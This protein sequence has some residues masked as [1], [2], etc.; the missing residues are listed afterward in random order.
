MALGKAGWKN[1]FR[2]VDLELSKLSKIFWTMTRGKEHQV[3]WVCHNGRWGLTDL[4]PPAGSQRVSYLSCIHRIPDRSR[5]WKN[6]HSLLADGGRVLVFTQGC[7]ATYPIPPRLAGC[8]PDAPS[9][10]TLLREMNLSG[11]SSCCAKVHLVKRS[12]AK[13]L[14]AQWL[15]KGCFSDMDYCDRAEIENFCQTLP[16]VVEIT[17]SYYILVGIKL[18][19]QSGMIDI[20]PSCVHG[21][22]GCARVALQ[23][24]W[25]LLSVPIRVAGQSEGGRSREWHRRGGKIGMHLC[26]TAYRLFNHSLQPNCRLT[27]KGLIKT[28]RFIEA[29]EELSLDYSANPAAD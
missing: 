26:S 3:R 8:V 2:G 29:G 27:Q 28:N 7:Q 10:E 21:L 11:L 23:E 12:V 14:W 13:T 15:M 17:M 5:F 16:D 25:V 4:L 22:C 20:R 9:V 24:D 1:F 19:P 18:G 6:L